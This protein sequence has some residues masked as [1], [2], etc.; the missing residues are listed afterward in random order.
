MQDEQAEAANQQL[1][2]SPVY[3][4]G[5][6]MWLH[7]FFI[8]TTRPSFKLDKKKLGRFRILGKV[9]SH[10]YKFHLPPSMKDHPIYYVT[11]LKPAFS[12]PLLEQQNPRP[13]TIIVDSE[14]K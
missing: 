8:R 5:D 14:E 13:P 7:R 2:P 1:L 3:N 6:A 11:L 10:D 4:V 9:F 12:D